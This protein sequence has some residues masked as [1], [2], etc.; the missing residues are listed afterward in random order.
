VARDVRHRLA[1]TMCDE[2]EAFI[3][4]TADLPEEAAAAVARGLP[5]ARALGA[6][7]FETI[8]LVSLAQ[9]DWHRGRHAE[10]RAH[11]HEAWTLCEAVGTAFAGGLVQGALAR[12]APTR[13]ERRRALR[14]GEA[15][16]REP[17]IWHS[18]IGFYRY[19]IDAAL[20]DGEWA[21]AE[22]Y[23]AL[24]DESVRAEPLPL[25]DLLVARA[26]ALA[27]AGRGNAP[28]MP[29]SR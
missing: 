3:L 15:L 6:R 7:R 25:V 18:R 17:A 8:L 1:E 28:Q 20:A 24:L 13:A 14:D 5:L 10:A 16:V 21:D 2:A 12:F 23:A 4:V 27:D 9:I 29:A 11:L 26:H 22:R 19:A